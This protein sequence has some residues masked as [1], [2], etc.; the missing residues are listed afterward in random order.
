M[1]NQ[2]TQPRRWKTWLRRTLVGLCALVV[3]IGA[4]LALGAFVPAITWVG[5]LGSLAL[6]LWPGWFIIVPFAAALLVWRFNDGRLRVGVMALA[7]LTMTGAS[8]IIARVVSVAHANDVDVAFGNA[9]G[10]SQSLADVAPDEVVTYVRDQGDD[11]T[12]RIFKPTGNAPAAGW[13]V[14]MHI[15][16]G[17]WV[18]GSNKEQS[19][20]MRWFA[21]KGWVVISVGY[22]LSS[23]KRHLWDKV[24]PQ[25]GCAMA[26]T[27]DNIGSRGG[28]ARR[29]SLRGGSAGG[30]LSANAAY[31][32]NAGTLTSV[33]GGKIP[34]VQSVTPI[35][36]GADLVAIY[37][38]DYVP[39]GPD[40]KTMAER[41]TGGTPAQYPD[42]Y[43]A[44]A[45]ATHLTAAAPPTLIFMTENDHL[46][47]IASQQAFAEQVRKAGVPV[48]T[49]E[50][51]HGEHGFD[52]T[53]IGN[54]IVRQVSL[55][56]MRKYDK[57]AMV[58]PTDKTAKL[59]VD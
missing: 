46:V 22:S 15:H 7:L 20:D 23:T 8:V 3:L 21:D 55:E 54:A 30:N 18:E 26:W 33:C 50:I 41:Y 40:V 32:A 44:V 9:F 24:M 51:P 34:R 42:R 53:G 29:L 2:T 58:T 38:N 37:A 48:R 13:P 56:F 25:L 31:M 14:L 52:I 36:P 59:T 17:G 1:A 49:V 19:A 45:T 35:Y 6:T 10:F 4:V 43:R 28:D 11:L 27:N 39:N 5:V 47:P 12:L 16:G 57:P